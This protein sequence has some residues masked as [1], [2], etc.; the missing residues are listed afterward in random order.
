MRQFATKD[1]NT[2]YVKKTIGPP[3]DIQRWA[4]PT[5]HYNAHNERP[6]YD[7]I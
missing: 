5:P 6:Q 3:Y 1:Q 4:K 2:V 7:N